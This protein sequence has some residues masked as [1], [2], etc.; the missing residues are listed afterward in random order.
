MKVAASFQHIIQKLQ[1]YGHH[2]FK[3][4]HTVFGKR[5]KKTQHFVSR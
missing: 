5:K 4:N 3:L 2:P 1:L